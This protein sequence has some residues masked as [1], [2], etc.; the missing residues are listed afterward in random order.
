MSSSRFADRRI[1]RMLSPDRI[2]SGAG[3]VNQVP[4][5]MDRLRAERIVLAT[6][7][8]LVSKTPYIEMLERLLPDKKVTVFAEC[9]QHSPETDIDRL[10]SVISSKNSDAVLSIGGS[11]VFDAVKVATSRVADQNGNEP[12]SQVAIPTTLS[13]G[14]FTPGA[15]YTEAATNAKKLVLDPRVAPSC[16]ILDPEVTHHTPLDL[17]LATGI[18]A[19]DH[20]FEAIWSKRPHPYVDA[21][22]LEAIRLLVQNLPLS[23]EKDNLDARAACQLGA[24]MSIAGVGASGMRLSHFLGHQIGAHMHLPHGITSCILLPAVMRHLRDETL[25]AQCRIADAMDLETRGLTPAE[26]ADLAADNLQDFIRELDL[27]TTIS[28]AGGTLADIDTVARSSF[29]AATLLGLT[30]DLPSGESSVRD[31]LMKAWV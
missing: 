21:L 5:I 25:D 31:V 28:E 13:A 24:W 16:V 22:A 18:K 7:K 1:Y 26:A 29:E 23:R 9:R 15:G 11:S 14:E 4:K 19:L 10:A 3:T 17:W 8:S 30:A 27:P 6:S 2:E 20:A 12:I